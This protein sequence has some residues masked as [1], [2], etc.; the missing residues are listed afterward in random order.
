MRRALAVVSLGA[1]ASLVLA[2][3]GAYFEFTVVPPPTSATTGP[4]SP[5]DLIFGLLAL[6]GGGLGLALTG[7]SAI[8]G[9]V[10]AGT[11]RCRTWFVAIGASAAL[12]VLGL[13]A[14]A[15]IL[16][17]LPRSPYHPFMVGLLVPVTALVFLRATRRRRRA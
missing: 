5:E 4:Q 1:C 3:V 6:I 2:Q 11:E 8:V 14:T 7:V 10:I 17:G 13:G 16:L 12:V 9:L 15:F